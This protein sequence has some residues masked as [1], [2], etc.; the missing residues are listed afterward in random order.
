MHR[1]RER[2]QGLA[3]TFALGLVLFL[4]PL[5]LVF[6]RPVRALGVPV[7][8]LYLF[9]AWGLVIALGARAAWRLDWESRSPRPEPRGSPRDEPRQEASDA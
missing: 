7:L 4:P 1:E 9:L 3:A 6:N 5:L 2:H 8:F